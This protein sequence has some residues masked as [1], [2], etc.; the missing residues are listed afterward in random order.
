MWGD[1][2]RIL[3]SCRAFKCWDIIIV[4]GLLFLNNLFS[5]CSYVVSFVTKI[6]FSPVLRL[7]RSGLLLQNILVSL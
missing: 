2:Y 3:L 5:E 4:E 1:N 6:Y 7:Q